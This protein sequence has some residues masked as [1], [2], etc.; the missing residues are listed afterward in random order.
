MKRREGDRAMVSRSSFSGG[1]VL[2]PNGTRRGVGDN[3]PPGGHPVAMRRIGRGVEQFWGTACTATLTG[4][5]GMVTY[6]LLLSIFPVALLPLFVHVQVLAAPPL[7][8]T[9]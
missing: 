1:R 4:L 9:V 2:C 7:E 8:R 3:R 5:P 6:H